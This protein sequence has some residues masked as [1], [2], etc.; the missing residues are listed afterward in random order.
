MDPEMII[1]IIAEKTL[2]I[3]SICFIKSCEKFLQTLG[4]FT[5]LEHDFL[6]GY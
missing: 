5:W 3:Q 1:K 6:P 4:C 2:D